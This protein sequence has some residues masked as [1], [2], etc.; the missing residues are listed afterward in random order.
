MTNRAA[1]A[2]AFMF[3]DAEINSA[4]ITNEEKERTANDGLKR[5]KKPRRDAVVSSMVATLGQ[6]GVAV[7]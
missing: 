2:K 6:N 5:A 3:M 7:L 1:E 4:I